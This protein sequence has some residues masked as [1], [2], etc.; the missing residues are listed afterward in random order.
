MDESK[1]P[2]CQVQYTTTGLTQR[3]TRDCN[4]KLCLSCILN[5]NQSCPLCCD[6][7]GKSELKEIC[8]SFF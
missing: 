5:H 1:C 8:V 2:I 7:D 3:I 4:H 6:H